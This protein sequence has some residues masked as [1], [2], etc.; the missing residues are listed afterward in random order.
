MPD[1]PFTERDWYEDLLEL[2]DSFE[3]DWEPKVRKVYDNIV[4]RTVDHFDPEQT[5]QQQAETIENNSVDTDAI[6]VLLAS[7]FFALFRPTGKFQAS[8]R[9]KPPAEF[10]DEEIAQLAEEAIQEKPR[11]FKDQIDEKLKLIAVGEVD[12]SEV[13][14][15][16]KRYAKVASE[17]FNRTNLTAFGNMALIKNMERLYPTS[18][19]QKRWLSMRD[20]RVRPAH[21]EADKR[22]SKSGSAL[23][24]YDYFEVDGE[25]LPFPAGGLKRENNINCRCSIIFDVY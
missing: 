8:K 7:M 5:E 23:Y 6:S 20:G 18:I 19:I 16:A 22:Y 2:W 14:R 17:Q 3:A 15:K 11:R 4:N 9:G 25:F 13:E 10:S 21:V 24:L 1:Q 12:K